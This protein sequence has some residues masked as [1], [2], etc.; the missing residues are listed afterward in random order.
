MS[1][2]KKTN[3]TNGN[4]EKIEDKT[5]RQKLSFQIPFRWID[6]DESNNATAENKLTRK[7]CMVS[8][9]TKCKYLKY[10]FAW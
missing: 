5:S 10:I 7:L 6:N 4:V 8:M 1:F 3:K 9:A 2:E